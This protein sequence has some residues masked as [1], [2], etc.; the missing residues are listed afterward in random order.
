MVVAWVF[1]SAA[2]ANGGLMSK[3]GA[4]GRAPSGVVEVLARYPVGKGQ[5]LVLFKVDR[6]VL[7]VS[8]NHGKNGPSMNVLTE[9]VDSEDVAALIAKTAVGS[10]DSSVEKFRKTLA[11]ADRDTKEVLAAPAPAP[12]AKVAKPVVNVNRQAV[13]ATLGAR[14]GKSKEDAVA[15]LRR[16]LTAIRSGT[17]MGVS[18]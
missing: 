5:T 18:A 16:K 10:K 9:V 11:K 14:P 4:G 17:G 15:E 13:I 2:R 3:L 8:Q 7:V 12:A 6:R 1:K